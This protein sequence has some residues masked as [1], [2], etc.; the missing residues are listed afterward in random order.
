MGKHRQ[1]RRGDGTGL[2]G[3]CIALAVAVGL[4]ACHDVTDP[5]AAPPDP[6]FSAHASD[7]VHVPRDFA[8]I[9]EAI[10]DSDAERI[11][12]G[13]GMHAGALVTRPVELRAS[14][15]AV[16]TPRAD[17]LAGR[18]IGFA[19]TGDADGTVIHGFV[20][21]NVELG[22][23][24]SCQRLGSVADAVVVEH[25][26]F[27]NNAQGVTVTD[28]ACG[29][30]DGW[31]VHHNV[32]DDI[33]ADISNCGG[34]LGVFLANVAWTTVAQNRY[35]G[36]L[37]EP[38]CGSLFSTAAIFMTGVDNSRAIHNDIALGDDGQAFKFDVALFGFD[39]G[40]PN[41]DIVVANNDHRGS[42][43]PF[44]GI[45]VASFTNVNVAAQC[46][47]GTTLIDHT[48]GGDGDM[49][50]FTETN[51]RRRDIRPSDALSQPN[52]AG[53]W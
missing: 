13:P 26:I 45:H 35:K 5:A 6:E 36:T 28:V 52:V 48:G 31:L 19:L 2:V 25:N 34:G 3:T 8:T 49:E 53:V 32:F 29:E 1:V 12:V 42:D 44:F 18:E 43:A 37:F 39:F 33:R 50:F 10:D 38:P 21:D 15:R 47:F 30:G 27:I 24:S 17:I 51:C 16:I 14:G 46:N 7:V 20:F 41:E 22:I 4:T 9:Q 40:G 11:I 23:Y